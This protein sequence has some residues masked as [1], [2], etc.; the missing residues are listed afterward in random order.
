MESKR[1]KYGDHINKLKDKKKKPPYFTEALWEAYSNAWKD[2]K[3]VKVAKKCSENRKQGYEKVPPTHAN[4]SVSFE[5]TVERMTKENNGIYPGFIEAYKRTHTLKGKDSEE[6]VLCSQRA[7]ETMEK[8]SAMAAE[9]RANEIEVPD[10]DVI[11]FKLFGKLN[12]RKQISG[13]GQATRIY[14]PNA[15]SSSTGGSVGVSAEEVQRQVQAMRE[16]VT[17]EVRE[18]FEK[19]YVAKDAERERENA[20]KHAELVRQNEEMRSDFER[21]NEMVLQQMMNLSEQVKQMRS[22]K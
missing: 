6:G 4:G 9:L 16:Q 15:G 18:D 21:K 3:H 10:L 7:I 8:V 20:A 2:P 5:V 19:K 12:K 14:F 17:I 13:A 11:Y 1:G 22:E